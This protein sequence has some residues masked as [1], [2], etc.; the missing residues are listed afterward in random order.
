MKTLIASTSRTALIAL[1]LAA[2]VMTPVHAIAQ[3]TEMKEDGTTDPLLAPKAGAEVDA[4]ADTSADPLAPE[5]AD[6]AQD[7]APEGMA[8]PMADPMAP[9]GAETEMAEGEPEAQAVEGQITLQDQDTILAEDL[10]G[11]PVYNNEDEKVGDIN[12]LIIA[13]SG[14]VEG[15]VIG[16]GGFLGLGEKDV[17]I[18]MAQLQ[19]ATSEGDVQRLVTSASRA[20]LESA[21]EFVTAQEQ[22]REAEALKMQSETTGGTEIPVE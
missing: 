19:V 12:D 9:V 6:V 21:P 2:P 8:D 20:D 15:V 18:E 11:A 4:E 14:N 16:V 10:L 22:A 7:G 13:L 1:A 17:A 3:D 5:G